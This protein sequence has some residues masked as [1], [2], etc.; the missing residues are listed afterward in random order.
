[1][2]KTENN[3]TLIELLVVIAIIAILASMLLPALSKARET[4]YK[5]SCINRFKQVGTSMT[6]YNDA[7][8]GFFPIS[9]GSGKGFMPRDIY[10]HHLTKDL[11]VCE[12][13]AK[14]RPEKIYETYGPDYRTTCGMNS[15]LDWK[16]VVQLTKPSITW[17]VNENYYNNSYILIS[18]NDIKYLDNIHNN[19]GNIL[20]GDLHVD[21]RKQNDYHDIKNTLKD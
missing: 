21:W 4:A 5:I 10:P 19:G 9:W 16:K 18:I 2:K 13:F 11:L 1:M 20:F 8:D 17:L 14:L 12:T 7:N 3:F 15:N 6:L